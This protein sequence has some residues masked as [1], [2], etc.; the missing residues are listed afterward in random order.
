MAVQPKKP[1]KTD[2]GNATIK[3][4]SLVFKLEDVGGYLGSVK[5]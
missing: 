3:F 2:H 4:E 5:R 1:N